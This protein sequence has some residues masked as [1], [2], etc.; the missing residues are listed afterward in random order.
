M[1]R[2]SQQGQV[3]PYMAIFLALVVVPLMILCVDVV[4]AL[5]VRTHLQAAAD[6]ACEAA[7]QAL[8]EPAFIQSGVK[9][10]DLGKGA[11][12]AAQHFSATCSEKGLVRYSPSLTSVSLRSPTIVFCAARAEVELLIPVS[13]ALPVSVRT[14]S[15]LRVEKQ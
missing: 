10:I 13:P 8:D 4:R 11:G 2:R 12:W 9:R 14:V 3:M 5:Y 15:E 6:A 1:R 7:V